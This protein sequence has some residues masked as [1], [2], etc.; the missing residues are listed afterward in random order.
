MGV[1]L[2]APYAGQVGNFNAAAAQQ[3]V[4]VESLAYGHEGGN[5]LFATFSNPGAA[6]L[7]A[8]REHDRQRPRRRPRD[9]RERRAVE[10]GGAGRGRDQ[11]QPGAP[12]R[13]CKAF[14]YR[15][16]AI[17]GTGIA[18]ATPRSRLSDWLNAPRARAARRR[19]R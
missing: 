1:P 4:I 13:C 8:D 15:G 11:R 7:A 16:F 14:R 17:A 3:A 9:G 2:G 6:E 5:D 19:S 18:Q 12:P 10:H